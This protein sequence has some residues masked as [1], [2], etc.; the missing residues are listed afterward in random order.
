M[1]RYGN[2][3]VE[4]KRLYGGSLP[5]GVSKGQLIGLEAL[6]AD[7]KFWN[8]VTKVRGPSI[9]YVRSLV[10]DNFDGVPLSE[11]EV[12][13]LAYVVDSAADGIAQPKINFVRSLMS[14]LDE[15][16]EQAKVARMSL[17]YRR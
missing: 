7:Q 1:I 17:D 11:A 15:T 8:S 5:E 13:N 16:A 12:R 3:V 6:V 9:E 10:V 4:Y 14:R 2:S